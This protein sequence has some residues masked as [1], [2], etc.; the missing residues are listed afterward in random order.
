[1]LLKIIEDANQLLFMWVISIDMLEM[2][3]KKM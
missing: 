2:R 3:T 1:M